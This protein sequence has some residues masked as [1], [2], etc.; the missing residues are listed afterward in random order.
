[1]KIYE[2]I[3]HCKPQIYQKKSKSYI[4]IYVQ[5]MKIIQIVHAHMYIY[6]SHGK[7]HIQLLGVP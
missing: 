4:L 7:I 2:D 1:M 5:Q 3:T 6:K